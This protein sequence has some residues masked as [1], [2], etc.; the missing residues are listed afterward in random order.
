MSS[1]HE[2]IQRDENVTEAETFDRLKAELAR[3]FAAPESAYCRLN[4]DTII[5][6]GRPRGRST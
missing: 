5:E 2:P 1:S 3:A 6:R 4:A